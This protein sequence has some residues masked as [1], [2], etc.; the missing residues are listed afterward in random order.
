MD[1]SHTTLL[2]I[3]FIVIV[4]FLFMLDMD[5]RRE[6]HEIVNCMSD[7]EEVVKRRVNG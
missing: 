6:L 5:V 1:K 2:W 3:M 7:L 4:F